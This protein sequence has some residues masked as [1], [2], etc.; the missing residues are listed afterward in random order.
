M[1]DADPEKPVEGQIW[2][3]RTENEV[4][5]FAG[6]QTSVL[7]TVPNTLFAPQ[8]EIGQY[9]WFF[10]VTTG[11][12]VVAFQ[13]P[14]LMLVLSMTGIIGP[15]PVAKYRKVIVFVLAS[16]CVLILPSQDLFTNIVLPLVMW[17]LFELGLIL[18]RL[19]WHEPGQDEDDEQMEEST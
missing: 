4:R 1:L 5:V 16:S 3:S 6:G 18:M 17:G 15:E 11:V 13:I 10:A 8:L 19:S 14:M 12:V 2:Y 9:L 7:P